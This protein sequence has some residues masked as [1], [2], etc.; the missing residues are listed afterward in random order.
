[1]LLCVDCILQDGHRNHHVDTIKNVFLSI[2]VSVM[3]KNY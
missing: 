3:K 1:M 2:Y